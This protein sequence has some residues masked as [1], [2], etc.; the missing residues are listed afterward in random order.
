LAYFWQ[1]ESEVPFFS[2]RP[3]PN[4]MPEEKT[5]MIG[6]RRSG[7]LPVAIAA[8]FLLLPCAAFGNWSPLIT[9]LVADGFEE[10]AIQ[11]LFSRPEV[12]FEPVTMISKLE[13]LMKWA[14]RKPGGLPSYNPG[15]VY[16]GFLSEKVLARARAYLRENA[17]F[18][19]KVS[20]RYCVPKEIIVSILLVETRLGD[21][22]GG[23]WAFNALAG[24]ALCADI[25]TVRSYLPKKLIHPGNEEFARAVCRQ[26]SEW[27]YAELKAL[28][29][30]AAWSGLDPLSLP[31]SIYGA[32]GLCQFMPSNVLSYAVDADRDGRIDLFAK[33][34]ALASIA[35][36]LREHGWKCTLD[37]PGQFRV[38]LD[39]NRSS[40]YANTVLAV[41]EKLRENSPVKKKTR[42]TG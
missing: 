19:E 16:K 4:R 6:K 5:A 10:S 8:C 12:K 14:H 30:Y 2:E 37:K 38:I 25:E 33:A 15:V 23:R 13:E 34:D 40:V 9:R 39:Y 24:M 31:G 35:N 32:I 3:L 21:F 22:L 28:I 26:K 20:S 42:S 36:Y 29:W 1:E 11:A 27:A 18:L 7:I 17:D 41:A